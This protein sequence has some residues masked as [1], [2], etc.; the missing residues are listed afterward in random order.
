M[1]D[2]VTVSREDVQDVLQELPLPVPGD[3]Y[4]DA[5]KRL[6]AA[7]GTE[8]LEETPDPWRKVPYCTCAASS[9]PPGPC[10]TS[11]GWVEGEGA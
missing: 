9:L 1:S 4:Y 3:V 8:D 6:E 7:C 11:C 5:A 10:E 2:M